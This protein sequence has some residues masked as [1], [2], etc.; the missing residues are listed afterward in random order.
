MGGAWSWEREQRAAKDDS[1]GIAAP[2]ETKSLHETRGF[3]VR[4]LRS[5]VCVP[6]LRGKGEDF[7][8]ICNV[9]FKEGTVQ[10]GAGGG[11]DMVEHC[12]D[13][14][15]Y[16][17]RVVTGRGDLN[18]LDSWR[19]N[20]DWYF[21]FLVTLLGDDNVGSSRGIIR[22][23]FLFLWANIYDG[24]GG[25]GAIGGLS[26]VSASFRHIGMYVV[27]HT[28]GSSNLLNHKGVVRS[29]QQGQ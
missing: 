19:G 22:E 7:F 1:F 26:L 3:G 15:L 24:S 12:V 27:S 5:T 14:G 21:I 20:R 13:K 29:G 4:G 6:K 18:L 8:D 17:G 16:E 2:Y 11:S 23:H 9:F 10:S 25:G 28:R